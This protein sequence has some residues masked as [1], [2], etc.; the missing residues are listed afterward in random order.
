MDTIFMNFG[1]SKTPDSYRLWIN[2]SDKIYV[3]R[4]DT[5]VALSNLSTYYT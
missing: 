3:K 1:N 4:S 5:Y 2:I